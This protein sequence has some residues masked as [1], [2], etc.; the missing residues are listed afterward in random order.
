MSLSFS[1]EEFEEAILE[2]GKKMSETIID[3]AL[4][5]GAKPMIERMIENVPKDSHELK[6]SI[7]VTKLDGSKI[8]RKIHIGSDSDDRE[9]IE[10]SYYQEYGTKNMNGTKW[11]SKSYNEA[12]K[13]AADEIA[14]HLKVNL[15]KG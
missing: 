3:D 7:G 9:I 5:E 1:L 10:R 15:F 2:V 6:N 4:Q 13:S 11:I 8:N 12:K 14:K